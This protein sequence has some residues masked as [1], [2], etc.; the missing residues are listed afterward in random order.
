MAK[1]GALNKQPRKRA[2]LRPWAT[3]Q[4]SPWVCLPILHC[5][6]SGRS[7][8][9]DSRAM[10]GEVDC[11]AGSLGVGYSYGLRGARERGGYGDSS[12]RFMSYE[13]DS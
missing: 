9:S 3:R 5:I 8:Q 13:L 1:T 2:H 11:C 4:P 7:R 12:L 10:T 6:W